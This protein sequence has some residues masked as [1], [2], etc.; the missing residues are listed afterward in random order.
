MKQTQGTRKMRTTQPGKAL[1]QTRARSKVCFML[2][3]ILVMTCQAATQEANGDRVK[4]RLMRGMIPTVREHEAQN[5]SAR[6]RLPSLSPD[7]KRSK[8]KVSFDKN[9]KYLEAFRAV[10][11]AEKVIKCV[12]EKIRNPH[13]KMLGKTKTKQDIQLRRDINE[14]CNLVV[15]REKQNARNALKDAFAYFLKLP[16]QTLIDASKASRE[17]GRDRNAPTTNSKCWDEYVRELWTR[18]S[19]D[20]LVDNLKLVSKIKDQCQESA[21]IKIAITKYRGKVLWRT[22]RPRNDTNMIRALLLEYFKST[23]KYINQAARHLQVCKSKLEEHK[24]HKKLMDETF[25][26]DTKAMTG[27]L[28]PAIEKLRG[29][30]NDKTSKEKMNRLTEVSNMIRQAF[31]DK[32]GREC[33][34]DDEIPLL[35]Y[36]LTSA[37]VAECKLIIAPWDIGQIVKDLQ[38]RLFRDMEGPVLIKFESLL[39]ALLTTEP[40]TKLPNMIEGDFPVVTGSRSRA[41]SS[42]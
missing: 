36:V 5:S 3:V 8:T 6:R 13:L 42:P 18:E 9:I 26:E 22:E 34:G 31:I 21:V 16:V 41:K 27:S 24:H 2:G 17:K 32:T 28:T 14:G 19:V 37:I 25:D 29:I 12:N 4:R 10:R 39:N 40:A 11:A 20:I 15:A 30:V 35:D 1:G 7:E 38:V 23:E 33:A